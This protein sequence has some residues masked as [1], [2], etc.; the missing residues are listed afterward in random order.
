MSAHLQRRRCWHRYDISKS[1]SLAYTVS[2]RLKFQYAVNFR[3]C[4]T[5]KHLHANAHAI[6]QCEHFCQCNNVCIRI[7]HTQHVDIL[8]TNTGRY[9]VGSSVAISKHIHVTVALFDLILRLSL[10]DWFADC[11]CLDIINQIFLPLTFTSPLR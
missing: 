2:H 10:D 4:L 5:V 8:L 3:I 7:N 9:G 6:V 11:V 1:V